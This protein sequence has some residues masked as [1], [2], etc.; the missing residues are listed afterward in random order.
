MTLP[1]NTKTLLA[2]RQALVG[3]TRPAQMFPHGT[4]ELPLPSG[5]GRVQT[6]SGIFHFDPRRIR[7]ED[8]HRAAAFGRENKILGLGPFSKKD[9]MVR[10][11]RGEAPTAIVERRPDGTEVRASIATDS[12]KE[13]QTAAMRQSVTTGNLLSHENP[14]DTLLRRL[15]TPVYSKGP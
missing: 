1:E 13:T 11:L 15:G 4:M 6:V 3:G 7:P 2:Q 8:I 5:M 9:A 10:V 12:T 14:G